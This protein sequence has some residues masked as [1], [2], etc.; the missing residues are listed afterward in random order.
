M[1]HKNEAKWAGCNQVGKACGHRTKNG[2]THSSYFAILLFEY[3]LGLL[4]QFI[5]WLSEPFQQYSCLRLSHHV[6]GTIYITQPLPFDFL[7]SFHI[8]Y[9]Y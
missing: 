3:N 7:T 1:P 9:A 5:E 8:F 4:E 2:V 6:M